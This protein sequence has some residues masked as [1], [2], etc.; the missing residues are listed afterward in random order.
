MCPAAEG[1]L[2]SELCLWG[3][4]G[5]ASFTG[6]EGPLESPDCW[7]YG[8]GGGAREE[9]EDEEE[10]LLAGDGG[11]LTG[12]GGAFSRTGAGEGPRCS[13]VGGRGFSRL[14]KGA[15]AFCSGA[16]GAFPRRDIG[17]GG[18][19]AEELC[20][21]PVEGLLPPAGERDRSGRDGLCGRLDS[22]GETC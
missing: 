22:G 14:Y 10:R 19:G 16:G 17:G 3:S 15:L 20:F 13:G 18:G 12:G 8:G 5:A 11:G 7:R 6:L 21:I 4:S 2:L 1:F 9:E